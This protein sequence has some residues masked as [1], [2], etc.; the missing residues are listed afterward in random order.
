M[1]LFGLSFVLFILKLSFVLILS[2]NELEMMWLSRNTKLFHCFHPQKW[3]VKVC[4]CDQVTQCSGSLTISH[5]SVKHKWCRHTRQKNYGL[6][7]I[8]RIHSIARVNCGT[9]TSS[10]NR[11]KMMFCTWDIHI[12]FIYF[13]PFCLIAKLWHQDEANH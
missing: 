3:E 9:C 11:L 8:A 4:L 12:H 7:T 10:Q 13:K 5:L 1:N 2:K 6:Y